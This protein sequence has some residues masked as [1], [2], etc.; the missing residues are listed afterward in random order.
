MFVTC[1]CDCWRLAPRAHR[2]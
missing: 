2:Q 1:G